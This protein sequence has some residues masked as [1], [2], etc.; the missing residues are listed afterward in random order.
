MRSRSC[1][2]SNSVCKSSGPRS[3]CRSHRSA[4][5]GR[6]WRSPRPRSR[7][8]LLGVIDEEHDISDSAF[9]YLAARTVSVGGGVEAQL[10]RV[11]PFPASALMGLAVPAGYGDA[12]ARALMAAGRPLSASR[13]MASKRWVSCASKKAMSRAAKV[14]WPDDGARDLGLARMMSGRRISSA[15]S[16]RAVAALVDPDR[17]IL[18]GFKHRSS[19]TRRLRAGAHFLGLGRSTD[20]ANDEGYMTS[21]AYSPNLGHWIGLGLIKRAAE[22][23]RRTRARL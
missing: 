17:P 22:K 2:T 18:A 14:E 9:G 23:H 10:F 15:A 16:W 11:P 6:K 8:L 4:S 7:D 5:N 3:T 12:L 20:F 1:S 21:V 19:R 13:P